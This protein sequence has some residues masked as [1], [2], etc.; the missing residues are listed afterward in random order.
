MREKRTAG[1][2]IRYRVDDRTD[3]RNVPLKQFL[4]HIETKA[5]LTA[6]L[7]AKVLDY[8]RND[9]ETRLI[10]VWDKVAE[11]NTDEI[12]EDI[13]SHTHEEADTLIAL[14]SLDA[15]KD[16]KDLILDVFS[17]DT[18]VLLLLLYWYQSLCKETYF[19]TGRGNT[20]R[21]IS[22]KEIH[23]ALG[24]EKADAILGFH[25]LTGA[26]T[27]GRFA[28]KSKA[29]CFKVFMSSDDEIINAFRCLGSADDPPSGATVDALERFVCCL[30]KPK[31]SSFSKLSELR[32]H[33]FSQKH[34]EGER[35]P[36]TVGTLMPHILRAHFVARI[37]KTSNVPRYSLPPVSDFGWNSIDDRL[38]PVKS[39]E[40]PAPE[41]ILM[42]VK[43]SCKTDCSR[44]NCSCVKAHVTCTEMCSC[45]DLCQ[46]SSEQANVTDVL[47]DILE[48]DSEDEF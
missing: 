42:L 33:L 18:D 39:L 14:H 41:S 40:L 32:R 11:C 27:T 20:K 21:S 46:N 30:Y 38:V 24:T 1:N 6:Y 28:G 9:Q 3:I 26:D 15:S 34:A 47:D 35:L 36:P 22:V 19:L 23:T 48:Y 25:S 5:E 45:T 10:V 16:R 43:C 4:S 2:A 8:F 44:A 31:G 17:P 29:T 13:R 7:A 37:W 12:N